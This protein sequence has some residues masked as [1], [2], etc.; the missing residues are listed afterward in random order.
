M[1]RDGRGALFDFMQRI[2]RRM[3]DCGET[4]PLQLLLQTGLLDRRSIVA[5][6]PRSHAYFG[7]SRFRFAELRA[8]GFDICVGTDSLASNDDLSMLAELRQLA[9]TEP[10]L[11]PRELLETVTVN[12]AAALAQHDTPGRIRPGFTADLIAVPWHDHASSMLDGVI[13]Y[14]EKIPWVIVDGAILPPV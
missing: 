4:T 8:L 9:Q 3:H 14:D 1:F 2:G 13:S 12:A 7:H 5:H 6:C 11:S 10:T